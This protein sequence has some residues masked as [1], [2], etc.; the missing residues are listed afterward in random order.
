M[1]DMK[2]LTSFRWCILA[3]VATALT[4]CA[5]PNRGSNPPPTGDRNPA[6]KDY[7]WQRTKWINN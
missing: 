6:Q 7:G 3:V 2:S 1:S 4:A 5:S